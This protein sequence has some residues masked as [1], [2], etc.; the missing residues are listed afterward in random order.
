[1]HAIASFPFRAQRVRVGSLALVLGLAGCGGSAATESASGQ[2]PSAAASE[3]AAPAASDTGPTEAA[4][5][6]IGDNVLNTAVVT[7]G[8][9]RYEF[10]DVECS[11]FTERYIQAGNF[12]GDPEVSIVLPPEGWESQ[13]DTFGPPSVTVTIGDEFAGGAVL[14]AGDAGQ[15]MINPIPDGQSQIDSYVVPDGRPVHAT[16]TATFID[17]TAINFGREAVPMTG[18]FEVTCP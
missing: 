13:G 4:G 10:T 12:G 11:I 16:G 9:D 6:D 15:V 17:T 18:T 1:M 2:E 8:D 5:G 14:V 7:I 3:P